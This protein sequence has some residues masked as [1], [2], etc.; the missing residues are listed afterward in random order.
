[1]TDRDM[2]VRCVHPSAAAS[3]LRAAIS[4]SFC[5]DSERELGV[6]VSAVQHGRSPCCSLFLWRS[7]AG[8]AV[9]QKRRV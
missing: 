3:A 7:F 9:L 8:T 4:S 5:D 2:P 1:V 6:M